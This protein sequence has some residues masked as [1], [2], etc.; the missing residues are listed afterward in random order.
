MKRRQ[1]EKTARQVFDALGK[2]G[3]VRAFMEIGDEEFVYPSFSETL[4][5]RGKHPKAPPWFIAVSI[6][7]FFAV[8]ALVIWQGTRDNIPGAGGQDSLNEKGI[9]GMT[10][11]HRAVINRDTVAAEHLCGQG[12]VVDTPDDYG[13]TPLHWAVFQKD[14][15]MCR[16]LLRYRARP[17][18]KS[19]RPWFKYPK[20]ITPLHMAEMSKHKE[21]HR[22]LLSPPPAGKTGTNRIPE[23]KNE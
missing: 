22:L 20:G 18:V 15:A 2:K 1:A 8:I 5:H 3:M 19:T 4:N 17:T 13:W 10:H 14:A 16:L 23:G 11:L 6:V 12:A 21:I 7:I 9:Y